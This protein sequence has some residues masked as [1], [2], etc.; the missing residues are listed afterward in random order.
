[1]FNEIMPFKSALLVAVALAG[2]ASSAII[3]IVA[4]AAYEKM[5]PFEFVPNE[6]TAQV[7]DILKFHFTGPANGVLGGNHSVRQGVFGDPCRP[8][9]NGFFSGY[10][11]VNA[12]AREAVGFTLA[13][14]VFRA[15]ATNN[16]SRIWSS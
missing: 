9:P 14:V 7:G 3:K 1:L 16:S 4:Q 10:M 5:D 15:A 6:V 2:Q 13:P 11:P 12:T 8:A